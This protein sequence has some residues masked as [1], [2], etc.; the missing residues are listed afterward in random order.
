[1]CGRIGVTSTGQKSLAYYFFR[2]LSWPYQANDEAH[3]RSLA[4]ADGRVVQELVKLP[5]PQ[6]TDGQLAKAAELGIS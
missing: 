3:A 1:L 5:P 4:E 2:I 6:A